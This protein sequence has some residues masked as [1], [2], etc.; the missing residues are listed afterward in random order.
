MTAPAGEQQQET[1][2]DGGNAGSQGDGGDQKSFTQ[3]QLNAIVAQ[4]RRET[5]SKFDGHE[6]LKKKANQLDQLTAASKSE[7]ERV[8]D[9][10]AA[11]VRERDGFKSTN[12]ELQKQL[13]RQKISAKNHLDADLWDRVKGDTAEE[14]EADVKTLVSKFGT[15]GGKPSKGLQSGASAPDGSTKKQRAAVALRGV[16]RS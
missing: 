9:E 5:E 3:A 7:V 16:T 11:A 13:L 2:A 1:K 4:T 14:I 15:A 6:D 12:D 8:A 10:K